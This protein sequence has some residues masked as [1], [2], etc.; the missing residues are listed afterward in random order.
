MESMNGSAD[1]WR[2]LRGMERRWSMLIIDQ[3]K[4]FGLEVSLRG[5]FELSVR[6]DRLRWWGQI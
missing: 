3:L 1:L 2:D 6:F 4:E 5:E